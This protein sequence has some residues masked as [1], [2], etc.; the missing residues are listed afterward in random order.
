MHTQFCCNL[1]SINQAQEDKNLDNPEF[2]HK[3]VLL[4]EAVQLLKPE[5]KKILVDATLGGGGHTQLILESGKNCKVIATDWD[6]RAIENAEQKLK[7]KFG[8]RLELVFSSF[9]AL[10][11]I[12]KKLK[13]ESVDGILADFGTSQD[14]IF[15][16][17]GFSF[18]S[19]TPLDMRMS[20]SHK[21][22]TA[23]TIVN[24]ASQQELET[25]F[26]RYGQERF[27]RTIARRIVEQRKKAPLT[28]TLELAEL[29]R[30]VYCFKT[31]NKIH[32]KTH[33]AT[34]VFQALR[35]AVN[36]ELENIE[37]F[38]RQAWAAL[39]PGGRLVCISFH[40]LED[41]IVKDF[42]RNFLLS[43]PDSKL[44]LNKAL[45]PTEEQIKENPS[46]R[47]A[48]LRAIEK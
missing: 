43:N 25:I 6:K 38:L 36:A 32:F 31:K 39:K 41:R 26:S 40:S 35:I 18:S 3:T 24:Q 4:E 34:R 30:A 47:S 13:I 1:F 19:N 42:F 37:H 8:D 10:G 21:H 28:N 16:K 29:V 46:C 23:K 7:P 48:K 17:E 11:Q 12:L 15:N 5:G 27:S 20:T 44:V 2:K 45:P 22:T 14:Q 9:T 33:P